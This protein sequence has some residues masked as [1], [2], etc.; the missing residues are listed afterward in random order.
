[1]AGFLFPLLLNSPFP[2]P[3]WSK[4]LDSCQS[5]TSDYFPRVKGP[6]EHNPTCGPGIRGNAPTSTQGTFS[7]VPTRSYSDRAAA[8]ELC[9]KTSTKRIRVKFGL[10][11]FIIIFQM[12]CV[13]LLRF[14]GWASGKYQASQEWRSNPFLYWL[15]PV[16]ILWVCHYHTLEERLAFW[17]TH[18]GRQKWDYL[19]RGSRNGTTHTPMQRQKF[20]KKE[21]SK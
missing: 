20:E 16:R 11:F 13:L 12:P 2:Q 18:A 14:G 21:D 17:H 5:S 6:W 9:L 8:E 10:E 1:M 7:S 3:T 19:L 4:K 15:Q